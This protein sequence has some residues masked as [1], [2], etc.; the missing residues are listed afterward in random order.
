MRT[1]DVITE[2]ELKEQGFSF[3]TTFGF[4]KVWGGLTKE[5]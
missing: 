1:H 4:N 3:V 2:A 5:S